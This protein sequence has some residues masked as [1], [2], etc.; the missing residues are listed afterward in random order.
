MAPSPSEMSYMI[1]QCTIPNEP[2]EYTCTS[3]MLRLLTALDG[4]LNLVGVAKKIGLP[5]KV[6]LAAANQLTS[7]KL[8]APVGGVVQYLAKDFMRYLLEQLSTAVGPI[9]EI[10]IED[11]IKELGYTI[12]TIP[13]FKAPELVEIL[14]KDIQREDKRLSFKQNMLLRIKQG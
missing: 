14:A 6:I 5:L 7:Y 3:G 4:T 10:L 13:I 9:A 12:E 8:I 11:S 2:T 1:Y